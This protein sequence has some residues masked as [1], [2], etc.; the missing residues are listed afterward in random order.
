[1]LN[2]ENKTDDWTPCQPGELTRMV[3]RL[4]AVE[5]RTRHRQLA[6]T[7]LLSLLLFAVGIV[8]VGG[9][10]VFQ[11]PDFGGIRCSE[12]L[13]HAEDYYRHLRGETLMADLAVAEQMKTHLQLCDRCRDKFYMMYPD[14]AI[15][16]IGELRFQPP[17]PIFTVALVPRGY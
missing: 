12:C 5:R 17:R 15:S 11:E 4:D 2:D 9:L 14:V 8:L 3:K 7:G 13:V 1:M 10:G 6:R 16:A